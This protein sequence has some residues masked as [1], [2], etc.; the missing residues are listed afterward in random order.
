MGVLLLFK[1]ETDMKMEDILDNFK[2][3]D[4]L[5]TEEVPEEPRKISLR[6][7]HSEEQFNSFDG[8]DSVEFSPERLEKFIKYYNLEKLC[9]VDDVTSYLAPND[10]ILNFRGNRLIHIFDTFCALDMYI[11]D[12]LLRSVVFHLDLDELLC[13]VFGST[14]RPMG[15]P[16]YEAIAKSLD[17]F[18]CTHITPKIESFV[19]DKVHQLEKECSVVKKPEVGK[20]YRYASDK[21]YPLLDTYFSKVIEVRKTTVVIE[22]FAI[23]RHFEIVSLEDFNTNFK[24]IDVEV[25]DLVVMLKQIFGYVLN[26]DFLS[27]LGHDK[28]YKLEPHYYHFNDSA[29][30]PALLIDC[31][32]VSLFS[33]LDETIFCFYVGT[34]ILDELAPVMSGTLFE[35][36]LVLNEFNR[37][38]D[39]DLFESVK[40]QCD[41]Y[42]E[43]A[44]AMLYYLFDMLEGYPETAGV[45]QQIKDGVQTVVDTVNNR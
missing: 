42:E 14:V 43:T 28:Y 27:A 39:T 6:K 36:P 30:H 44:N 41:A 22:V 13:Y 15:R 34:S 40:K 1:E 5:H 10:A 33:R 9:V 35:L 45:L 12:Q 17:V 24:I 21:E 23:K 20:L 2:A 7:E 32:T 37:T 8:N 29:S 25:D 31:G 26:Q 3:R 38:G 18:E 19:K 16:N 4:V 11:V